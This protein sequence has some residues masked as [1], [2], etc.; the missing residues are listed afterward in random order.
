LFHLHCKSNTI[1]PETWQARGRQNWNME[2]TRLLSFSSGG[3]GPPEGR[4]GEAFLAGDFLG[5]GPPT[6]VLGKVYVNVRGGLSLSSGDTYLERDQVVKMLAVRSC[7][8]GARGEVMTGQQGL[9]WRGCLW[10][11][12]TASMRVVEP[13]DSLPRLPRWAS[14][15]RRHSQCWRCVE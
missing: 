10:C 13:L 14:V 4:L 5:E 3:P 6:V 2:Q 1:L 9:T 11:A 8:G 12:F 15:R 7:P